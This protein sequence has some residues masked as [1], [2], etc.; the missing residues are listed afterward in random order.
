MMPKQKPIGVF[1]RYKFSIVLVTVY[2]LIIFKSGAQVLRDPLKKDFFIQLSSGYAIASGKDIKL[3]FS[4]GTFI[5]GSI[6]IN[7]L[8]R[9]LYL[10]P[11]LSFTILQNKTNTYDDQITFFRY[12][13]SLTYFHA[14]DSLKKIKIYG[15]AGFHYTTGLDRIFQPGG[16]LGEGVDIEKHK[17]MTYSAGAGCMLG[18]FFIEICYD[19][20]RPSCDFNDDLFE[21][22]EEYNKGIY[23]IYEIVP[24]EKLNLDLMRIKIGYMLGSRL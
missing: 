5:D 7:L 23:E 22:L 12:G 4:G 2:F 10:Q 20:F 11:G 17:G 14:L 8:H 3:A 18:G 9:K 13:S 19:Y 16:Y 21:H 15:R 24:P 1:D 6:G